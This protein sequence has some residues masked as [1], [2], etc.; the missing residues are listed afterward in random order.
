MAEGEKVLLAQSL[1]EIEELME[2]YSDEALDVVLENL[3]Y[4]ST[5]TLRGFLA[6]IETKAEGYCPE[7]D[8]LLDSTSKSSNVPRD[9]FVNLNHRPLPPL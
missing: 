2:P 1:E 5:V 4:M 7:H 9:P 6:N 8:E 3:T